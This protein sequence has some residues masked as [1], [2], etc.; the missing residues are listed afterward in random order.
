MQTTAGIFRADSVRNPCIIDMTTTNLVLLCPTPGCKDVRAWADILLKWQ[1]GR[2]IGT[3]RQGKLP[4]YFPWNAFS[5]KPSGGSARAVVANLWH[6]CQNRHSGPSLLAHKPRPVFPPKSHT[7]P[8]RDYIW[9]HT[10]L[11][12][13]TKPPATPYGT[14]E[15]PL[16]KARTSGGRTCCDF[17]PGYFIQAAIC[18]LFSSI[19]QPTIYFQFLAGIATN[20]PDGSF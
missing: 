5:I 12:R 16:K 10:V 18:R 19:F 15:W 2:D 3:F 14:S 20:E 7:A 17:R 9:A 11:P 4:G 1:T 13:V 8:L 6:M